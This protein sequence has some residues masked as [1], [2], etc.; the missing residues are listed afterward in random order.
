MMKPFDAYRYY[1]ALKLHFGG[2]YDAIK[3]QFKTSA[4][5]KSFWNRKDKFFFA[6]IA[7]RFNDPSDLINYFVAHFIH[8]HAWVGNM[9]KDEEVYTDWVKRN[10][11]LAYNFEQDLFKLE[12]KVESFDDLF[13]LKDGPYPLIVQEYLSGDIM[14]ETVALMEKYFNV[15]DRL[16]TQIV[17]TIMWP[18]VKLKVQKYAPFITM[19]REKIKKIIL[20]VFTS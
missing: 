10:E 6:K 11:S 20:K 18:E 9:L 16:D 14:I 19:E 2:K 8:G 7:K 5:E 3:Y 13:A 12:E 1:N 15:M 17:D 4:N